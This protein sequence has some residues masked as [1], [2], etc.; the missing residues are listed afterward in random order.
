MYTN[1]DLNKA[2]KMGIFEEDSVDKF[3]QYIEQEKNTH[4]VDEENFR[5]VSGFND[6]FVVIAS[7]LLLISS[8]WIA[9]AIGDSFSAVVVALLAWGLSEYF[10]RKRKMSFPAIILL[11]AFSSSVFRAF[12]DMET[13]FR[14]RYN[15]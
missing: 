6:I 11:I 8:G 10:V 13:L 14:G 9:S 4:S 3:R 12:I 1:S 5:L 7:L 2:V 15:I